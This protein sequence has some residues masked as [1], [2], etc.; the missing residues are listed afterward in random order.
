MPEKKKAVVLLVPGFPANEHD[1]TCMPFLQQFCLSFLK[2]CPD[3]ELRVI[4]F[5]YPFKRG[6]YL[7]NGIKVY[8]AAGK[9]RKFNRL[10]TWMRVNIQF[11]NI[12]KSHTV[13][14]INSFW[15]TECAFVGQWLVRLFNSRHVVYVIGQDALK[16][17][18]YLPWINFSKM[19]IIAMSESLVN[20]FYEATGFKIKCGTPH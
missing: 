2:V 4:S 8:S 14:V 1:T 7:W 12:K 17:N 19:E 3:I 9:S 20:H 13:A 5:Q 11:L 16:R 18:R 10:L 6:H 15:M